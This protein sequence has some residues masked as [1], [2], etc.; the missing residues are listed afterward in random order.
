MNKFPST[1]EAP[2]WASRCTAWFGAFKV[3]DLTEWFQ[4]ALSH[5]FREGQAAVY[6]LVDKAQRERDCFGP[7]VP[8]TQAPEPDLVDPEWLRQSCISAEDRI[9][10][11]KSVVGKLKVDVLR[12]LKLSND[13]IGV[14]ESK[15]GGD[16]S[17]RLASLEARVMGIQ[18]EL[19]M[20]GR[21]IEALEAPKKLDPL[22]I[23][24][25][26]LGV[27]K[28]SLDDCR[29]MKLNCE[30][31]GL[32]AEIERLKETPYPVERLRGMDRRIRK[33]ERRLGSSFRGPEANLATEVGSLGERLSALEGLVAGM[34]SGGSASAPWPVASA[35]RPW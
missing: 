23:R 13:R 29:W 25:D 17:K 34:R 20:W 24:Y 26:D 16:W 32:Q 1:L 27:S 33:L 8:G 7:V 21:R 12:G 30:I 2:V 6:D 18:S 14:L 22:K 31:G 4:A 19:P 15:S 35:G 28:M 10:R 11:L 9:H 5:G 3:P